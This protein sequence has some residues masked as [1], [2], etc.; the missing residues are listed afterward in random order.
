M[1]IIFSVKFVLFVS[2]MKCY[3]PTQLHCL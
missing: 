3:S 1:Q 2:Q